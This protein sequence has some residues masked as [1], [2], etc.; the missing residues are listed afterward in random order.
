MSAPH[1]LA[2]QNKIPAATQ[3]PRI[4]P[5]GSTV[6][7]EALELPTTKFLAMTPGSGYE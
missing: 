3:I 7:R 5:D 4:G 6:A 2:V 1:A